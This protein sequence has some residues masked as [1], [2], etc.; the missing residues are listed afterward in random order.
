MALKVG[1]LYETI[2]YFYIC[3]TKI[4]SINLQCLIVLM[5][6]CIIHI[7]YLQS[8]SQYWEIEGSV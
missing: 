7:V 8:I 2:Y 6:S 4:T 1:L 5:P 3:E